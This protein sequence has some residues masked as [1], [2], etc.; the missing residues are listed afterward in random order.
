[1]LP[2]KKCPRTWNRIRKEHRAKITYQFGTPV[3]DVRLMK[4]QPKPSKTTKGQQKTRFLPIQ[5]RLE[6]FG[7]FQGPLGWD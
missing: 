6:K 5:F 1:M 4:K 3:L 2:N 7:V